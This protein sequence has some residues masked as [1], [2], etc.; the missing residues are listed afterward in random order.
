MGALLN[1]LIVEDS[2]DDAELLLAELRTSGF[3]LSWK[4]VDNRQEYAANLNENIHMIFSDFSLP[5]FS[6][7]HALEILHERGL[8]IPFLIISGTIGEEQAVE[9]LKAGATDYILKD[10]MERLPLVVK[11][12]LREAAERA[13]HRRV[14]A[15]LR[16]SEERFRQLAE[17]INEVFWI[18]DPV[19]NQLL[20]VSPACAA[21]WGRLP[22]ELIL[23]P[24]LWMDTIHPGDRPR[25]AHAIKFEQAPDGFDETYRIIRPDG[26]V[27][28]IRDR[29]FPLRNAAGEIYRVVGT[30]EDITQQRKLEEQFRQAQKMESIGQLAGG[31][32]HDFNNILMVIQGHASLLLAG[33]KLDSEAEESAR[34][35]C[36]AAERAANLTR[37][38]LMFSRKQ[39]SQPVVLD[40]N[41]IVANMTKMLNRILTEDILLQVNYA[42]HLPKICADAGMME[43]V[44]MNLVVNARDA[45]P[46]GGKLIIRTSEITIDADYLRLKPQGKLGDHVCLEV[47]DTGSGIS[48][49]ILPRIFEPF[50][51][52]KGSEKGTGL[53]LATVYGIIQQHQGWVTVYSE[54]GN[55]TSFRIYLPA[56]KI[57]QPTGKSATPDELR[58]GTETILLVEDDI[59]V[60][61]LNRNMLERC[62]YKVIEASSGSAALET[63]QRNPGG[64]D[65]VLTD[66]VMPGGMTGIELVKKLRTESP[67]LRFIYTS[68]YNADVIGKD[69]I[70]QEGVSFL[71][72]PY[73][74]RMLA[75]TIRNALDKKSN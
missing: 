21:I 29:G 7:P 39:V 6:A 64:I 40:M 46:D 13:K 25:V 4:C 65:L 27:R 22:S 71:Q 10:R 41:Q 61:A 62:G 70:L 56:V 17:N 53:G 73:P 5:Q 55:G 24:G 72:K 58:G 15:A 1:I 11:R 54:V 30:A 74:L 19:K 31:V 14:E 3:E 45:M 35:I 42:P 50:F 67:T 2:Q 34:E 48:P 9:S 18:I 23:S 26:S 69:F 37:Q 36:L 12:A 66:M 49:E 32:A 28:W 52:T 44:L 60:S 20:Y 75:Q 8:D 43:Q 51:T 59:S 57:V 38:L 47:S 16:E 63:W 68:G 33:P